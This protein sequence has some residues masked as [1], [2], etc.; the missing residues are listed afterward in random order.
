MQSDHNEIYRLTAER[1]GKSEQ[2]YKDIGNMVFASLNASF[3]RPKSLIIKLKG[4][5]MW[6]LR[7]KRMDIVM[8]H[9]PVGDREPPESKFSLFKYEN[10]VEVQNLFA[11]R[12]KEYDEFIELRNET[13]DKRRELYQLAQSKE[14]SQD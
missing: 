5:G 9:Y 4:V 7:K 11:E 1:T 14:S 8:K 6:Y 12:L 13:K 2:V 3:R 10:K